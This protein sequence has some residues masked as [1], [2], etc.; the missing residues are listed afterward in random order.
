MKYTVIAFSL[1]ILIGCKTPATITIGFYNVENLFDTEDEPYKF[2]EFYTP[3]SEIKWDKE[4]YNSKLQNLSQVIS[5]LSDKKAPEFLGL[6]EIENKGVIKDLVNEPLLKPYHYKIVHFESGDERGIDVGFIYQPKVFTVLY[7]EAIVV[8]LSKFNDKTRDILYVKGKLNNGE[9]LHF[10]VNHW[11]SR[12]GGRKE[13]EPKRIIAA[14]TLKRAKDKILAK[15]KSAKIIVM[16]DFNDEPANTSIDTY[17]DSEGSATKVNGNELY[18]PMYALEQADLGSYKY[19]KW[20]DMLDQI[21]VSKALITKHANKYHYQHNSAEIKDNEWMKQHG[22]KY[23][24]SP[25]RTFG[26]RTYLAGYSDHFPV[27]IKLKINKK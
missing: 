13:S 8:D 3:N 2:D 5:E 19:G 12:R 26:G 11:S 22:N 7:K 14:E 6:C 4:K 1:L 9:T 27:Y 15:N 18:N 24:G 20:W 16:G 25:L 17:L 10:F 21:M 23:E